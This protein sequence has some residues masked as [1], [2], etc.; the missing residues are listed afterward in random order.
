MLGLECDA[1]GMLTV[2]EVHTGLVQNSTS[3]TQL[4]SAQL[5]AFV[6]GSRVRRSERPIA[7]AVSPDSLT[8][9]D[10][11]LPT[12]SRSQVRGVGTAVSRAAITG[13]RVLQGSAYAHIIKSE[14][15]RR[16]LWSHHLSRPGIVETL[17]RA[18][19]ADLAGGFLTTKPAREILDLGAISGRMMD[20]VQGSSELDRKQPFRM[21]RTRMRWVAVVSGEQSADN[22]THFTIDNETTRTVRLT[23]NEDDLLAAVELCE[24]LA[25]HDWLLT[26]L[27][28]LI[29]RTRS[30]R[31]GRP[32]VVERLQPAIDDLLHLWM[33][34]ARLDKSM[35]PLWQGLEQ[36]TGF[37]QQW[38]ASVSW[39]R[40]Q[41][42][43]NIIT[44]LST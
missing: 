17:T 25:L 16:L 2:G 3:L 19:R 31:G 23:V 41:V 13:G 40:D 33:P 15:D 5:L 28:T 21:A 36:R 30:G 22:R 32:Q 29:E 38:T 11:R 34:E 35:L 42:M 6:P 44:L 14:A 7:H 27:L 39:I 24:N 12:S 4:L 20:R 9:V 18:D 43:L 26:T 8:G 37:T 10:C 1:N